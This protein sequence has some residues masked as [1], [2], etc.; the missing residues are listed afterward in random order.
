MCQ[1][2]EERE[3]DKGLRDTQWGNLDRVAHDES[4]QQA[5]A[6]GRVSGALMTSELET[7]CVTTQGWQDLLVFSIYV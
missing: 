4:E 3:M 7:Q 2:P 5:E 1:D 6:S